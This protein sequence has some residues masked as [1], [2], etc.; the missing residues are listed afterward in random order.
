MADDGL[1]TRDRTVEANREAGRDVYDGPHRI[2]IAGIGAGGLALATRLGNTLAKRGKATI[3]LIDKTRTHLWKPLLHE[4]AAG[5]MHL[6][7]HEID[8][9]AQAHWPLPL[10]ITNFPMLRAPAT[11]DSAVCSCCVRAN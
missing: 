6:G 1:W 3:T 4:I 5:S 10:P 8:Y 11:L 9:L 7:V 2:V